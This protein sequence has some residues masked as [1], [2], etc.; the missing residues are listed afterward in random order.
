[1]AL[2]EDVASAG[3]IDFGRSE[4]EEKKCKDVTVSWKKDGKPLDIWKDLY[5]QPPQFSAQ[6]RNRRQE[7]QYNNLGGAG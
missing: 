7:E 2:G 5:N 3:E 1:M 4:I 6:K